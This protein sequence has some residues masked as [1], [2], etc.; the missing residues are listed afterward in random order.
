MAESTLE[1]GWNDPAGIIAAMLGLLAEDV[2]TGGGAAGGFGGLPDFGGG[3]LASGMLTLGVEAAAAVGFRPERRC[4]TLST[5]LRAQRSNP[6]F[7]KR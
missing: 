4:D 5:S 6:S 1:A 3:F 2:G 7:L